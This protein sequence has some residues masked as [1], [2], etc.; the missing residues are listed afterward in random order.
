MSTQGEHGSDDLNLEVTVRDGKTMTRHRIGKCGTLTFRNL[1]DE[2]LMIATSSGQPPFRESGCD[3]P[4]SAFT[5]APGTTK[6]VRISDEYKAE[7]FVYSARIGD[8]EPEDPIIII[9]RR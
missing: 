6:S 7:E 1:A 5:V 9:D 4:V 2:P 8:A 3:A